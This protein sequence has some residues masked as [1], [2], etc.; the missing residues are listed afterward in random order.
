VK[1]F[2]AALYYFAWSVSISAII[3][4][5][6]LTMSGCATPGVGSVCKDHVAYC[7]GTTALS[8]QEG[9]LAAYEC[10]GSQGCSLTAGVVTC[11][12]STNAVAG[13]A[14]LPGYEGLGQ[15]TADG[16][17]ILECLGAWTLLPCPAGTSCKPADG[18]LQCQ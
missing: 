7:H 12:Q 9:K 8:C 2:G 15:C 1:A 5:L 14:C 10:T 6:F 3:V 11:D 16:S 18:Y 17:G 13:S 4:G